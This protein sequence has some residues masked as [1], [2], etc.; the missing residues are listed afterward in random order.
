MT[1]SGGSAAL[2]Y[3]T[4]RLMTGGNQ[5]SESV[6]DEAVINEGKVFAVEYVTL[7]GVFEEPAVLQRRARPA[8]RRR[9]GVVARC[10][11]ECRGG[12]A[13]AELV[14]GAAKERL[15]GASAETSPERERATGSPRVFAWLRA[16][17]GP[18][19]VRRDR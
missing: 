3:S 7:D 9:S 4:G 1:A 11:A 12:L 8:C 5:R 18:G 13:G 16:H 14:G 19:R 6:V 10:A 15:P 17:P 2:Q